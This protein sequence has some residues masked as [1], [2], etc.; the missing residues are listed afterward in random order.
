MTTLS[1]RLL[2]ASV[3]PDVISDCV[4]IIDK[5]VK[6]KKGLSG[7]ALKGAYRTVKA[8]KRGFVPG[9]VDALLDEWVEKL[10]A[11]E[12]EH[13]DKGA[14]GTLG[15]YIIAERA[16]VAEALLSVTDGRAETTKHKTAKKLYMRFRPKAL[17][18]VD[19][20][21]PDLADLVDRYAEP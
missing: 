4:A 11:F 10:S 17:T 20:A 1:Q 12:A 14:A 19:E 15:A 16:R 6:S 3:R 21:L 18:N 8:I 9:V 2:D 5:Q 7:A 13:A